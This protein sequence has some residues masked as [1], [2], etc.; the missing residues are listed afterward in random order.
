MKK[1]IWFYNDKFVPADQLKIPVTDLAIQRGY[2]VFETLRTYNGQVFKLKE[3]VARLFNSARLIK[4]SLPWSKKFVENKV[5]ETIEKNNFPESLIKII[6]AGGQ[7]RDFVLPKGKPNLCILVNKLRPRKRELYQKGVKVITFPYQRFLSQAK[8]LDYQMA[9]V[10]RILAK[11]QDAEE[12]LYIDQQ[13]CI[14]EGTT[15]NFFVITGKKL[16]TPK[17][18]VLYGITRAEVIRL[19]KK[20]GLTVEERPLK[21]TEV[22]QVSEAFLTSSLP[23]I[24]PVVLV[25][26]LKIGNGKPGKITIKLLAEFRKRTHL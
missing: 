20:L 5:K 22:R 13:S 4:L 16:I 2:G 24:L 8:T 11:K 7:T 26:K 6:V 10:A 17:D 9:V 25:D 15:S 1:P 14:L 18:G 19:A 21:L 12:A 3:H 23:E